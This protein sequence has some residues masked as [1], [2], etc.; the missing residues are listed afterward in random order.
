M[1]KRKLTARAKMADKS[2]N[3]LPEAGAYHARLVGIIEMG[4]QTM[5]FDGELREEERMYFAWELLGH[6]LPGTKRNHV[7]GLDC[8]P[9]LHKKAKLLHLAEGM[10]G[11]N[12]VPEAQYDPVDWLGT[13]CKLTVAEN[14]G[15]WPFVKSTGPA[16]PGKP[17]YKSMIE[18]VSLTLDDVR[19]GGIVIVPTWLPQLFGRF[20]GDVIAEAVEW[21]PQER[22]WLSGPKPHEP[23]PDAIPEAEA[24]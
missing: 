10:L 11:K 1:A 15:G 12:L 19:K 13:Y 14:E 18:P 5:E 6:P 20:L 24:V 16:D 23:A 4:T 2:G 9:S 3:P 22:A 7:I 21:T 17:R 8:L